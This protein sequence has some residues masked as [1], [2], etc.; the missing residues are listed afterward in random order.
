MRVRV[1]V[2]VKSNFFGA[3]AGEGAVNFQILGA[4]AVFAPAPTLRGLSKT[5]NTSQVYIN[6]EL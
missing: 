5:L 1:L 4:G 2:Q 6:L 3:G